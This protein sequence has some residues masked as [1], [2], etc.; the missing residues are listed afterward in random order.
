MRGSEGGK[1]K[2]RK[3]EG[4]GREER[5]EEVICRTKVK[6][7]PTRLLHCDRLHGFGNKAANKNRSIKNYSLSI[8]LTATDQ[9]QQK[10]I[11]KLIVSI[12]LTFRRSDGE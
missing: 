7:L 6:L 2:E 10:I 8:V 9:K 1:G 3:R 12:T 11:K 5:R 4:E